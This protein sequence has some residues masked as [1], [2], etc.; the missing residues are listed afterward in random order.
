MI[1]EIVE[2]QLESD[3]IV[4]GREGKFEDAFCSVPAT[5]SPVPIFP[6]TLVTVLQPPHIAS[7]RLAL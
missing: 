3:A 4:T 2:P 5:L 7:L 6:P 1:M